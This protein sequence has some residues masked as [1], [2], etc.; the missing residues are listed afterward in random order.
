MYIILLAV[1]IVGYLFIA[2]EH[3]VKIDKAATA[4]LTGTLCW[5]IYILGRDAFVL[6]IPA[7]ES[8]H[9]VVESLRENLGEISEILFFLLGAMTIVE[10]IDAHEGFS[11]ITDKI[12][13]TNRV[14]LLWILSILTFFLSAALDNLTTA[15]VM[16]ALLRKL[17][18]DKQD[19]WM[20]A[21]LLIIAANAGGAW[22]PIGDVTT[23]MLWIGGQVTA[24]HIIKEIFLPSLVCLLV[25]LTMVSFKFKGNIVKPKDEDC[26]H[27][28]NF[29]VGNFDKNLVFAIGI[30]ALLFVPVFKTI[31]HLPPFMGVL[32]GL[33]VVWITTEILHRNKTVE[34]KK[35]L[36]I[37]NV[38]RRID[39]PSILFFLGILVAVGAL[40]S[41][42]HLA[43]MSRLLDD[44]FESIYTVN[45]IIG[46]LSSI[47]DNVPLVA[48]TMGM[49]GLDTYPP[50]SDFWELLAFC[51][52]TGGSILI[53]GSAAGVAIMGIL[54]IDFMWYLKHISLLAILGYI[55]GILTFMLVN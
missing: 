44:N 3:T 16:S 4:L 5:V 51:A 52:G 43:D 18:H 23:I 34:E 55:A 24:M 7:E 31:T 33:S 48:G 28:Q 27:T 17:I 40:Q 11:V 46:V 19:L 1:F 6:N 14:R 49:Y 29:E 41:A 54:K 2:L 8:V 37:S 42:G 39:T 36:A 9:F 20:F 53:I 47:V 45:S 35:N 13:T 21:G 38:L 50:D 15:I 30:G 12:T 32:L 26:S 22:S 25:P 10:I